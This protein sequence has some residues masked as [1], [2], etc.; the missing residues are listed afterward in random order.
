[1]V[2]V[3]S[4][5]GYTG[6]FA[7]LAI[8]IGVNFAIGIGL[9]QVYGLN[10]L[11]FFADT[12]TSADFKVLNETINVYVQK[13]G[14]IEFEYW[15]EFHNYDWE[16]IRIVDIGFPNPYYDFSSVEADVDGTPVYDIR[17]S[18]YILIGVEIHLGSQSIGWNQE[19]TVHVK[20]SAPIMVFRDDLEPFTM[21]SMEF[22]PTW[23]D[24]QFCR[25]T[26]F[27]NMTIYF[28]QGFTDGTQVRYHIWEPTSAAF[29]ATHLWYTWTTSTVGA[30]PNTYGVSFPNTAVNHVYDSW[31]FGLFSPI[32]KAI[33]IPLTLLVMAVQMAAIIVLYKKLK[34]TARYSYI[35]P[36]V[37]IECLG[38]R[39]GMTVVEAGLLLGVPLD[40]VVTLLVF[41]LVRK[42]ALKIADI[43]P[44]TFEKMKPTPK[45]LRH[46]EKDFLED[47]LKKSTG[48]TYTVS[49]TSLR[50][51]FIALIKKLN[52]KMKSY[53]RAET[54]YYYEKVIERA[55]KEVRKASDKGFDDEKLSRQFEW[56]LLDMEVEDKAKKEEREYF[57]VPYW[58][59]HYHY[60]HYHY[61][62]WHRRPRHYLGAPYFRLGFTR[63]PIAEFANNVV[64]G[65]EA[66]SHSIVKNISDFSNAILKTV[67]PPPPSRSGWSSGRHGGGGCA[68]ACACACAGC[69]C[70]CA[71]GGR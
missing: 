48:K 29:N 40:R 45:G 59:Y 71:G 27:L 38:V 20:G 55:W 50:A 2:K 11:M 12:S 54:E 53:S 23:F 36:K 16:S 37:G 25:G 8:F 68:C 67:Y 9:S 30:I 31:T 17:P 52:V 43:D 35:K 26:D 7:F 65:I 56:L 24:S 64:K 15:I 21:A 57:Y 46:Y 13:G 70:A 66:V 1:M 62:H 18:I 32:Q 44:L 14:G 42:N 39:R 63:L 6:L 47:G 19:K 51:I 41:G 5:R 4:L 69:A 58:Y 22:L 60:Y 34:K 28:P 61:W 33:A 10:P 3:K 49:Q